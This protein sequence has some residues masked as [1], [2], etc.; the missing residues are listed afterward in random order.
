MTDSFV[1][2]VDNNS[3]ER[4]RRLIWNEMAGQGLYSPHRQHDVGFLQELANGFCLVGTQE[5]HHKQ[6]RTR[7][8]D[9]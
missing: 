3:S 9:W 8:K 4:R 2:A 6:R 1:G 5:V 7:P